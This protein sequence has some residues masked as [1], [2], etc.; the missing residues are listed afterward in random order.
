M[1]TAAFDSRNR[2]ACTHLGATAVSR[3]RALSLRAF[4]NCPVT[5]AA[6]ADQS[7]PPAS[8]FDA[9]A[10]L[11]ESHVLPRSLWALARAPAA[12]DTAIRFYMRRSLGSR[13]KRDC[14]FSMESAHARLLAFVSQLKTMPIAVQTV[15]LQIGTSRQ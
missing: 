3:P 5:M 7:P 15:R 8:L 14:N 9:A 6:T 4:L 13:L 1:A 10:A 11:F 12:F 2:I